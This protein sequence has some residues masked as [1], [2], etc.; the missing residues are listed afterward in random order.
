MEANNYRT[1][2]N[3][4]AQLSGFLFDIEA[5][6]F[7]YVLKLLDNFAYKAKLVFL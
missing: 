6:S 5:I 1:I 3:M 2:N 7:P 4:N